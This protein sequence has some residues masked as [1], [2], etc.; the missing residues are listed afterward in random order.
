MALLP[1]LIAGV[2]SATRAP[3]P[4][5]QFPDA[6][7]EYRAQHPNKFK[8]RGGLQARAARARAA[9]RKAARM[10]TSGDT[11]AALVAGAQS[12]VSGTVSIPVLTVE[13]A[14]VTQPYPSS[15]LQQLLFDGPNPTGT[16]TDYYSEVSYGNLNV[17][18][19]VVDWAQLPSNDT[20]YEGAS[21]GL[22]PGAFS[23]MIFKKDFECN[24][25]VKK[26]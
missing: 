26:M 6:Y 10:A 12:V 19:T 5:Q 1:L 24:V 13:Y 20:V 16:L 15:T 8:L 21:N 9:Q 22:V 7:L 23:D 2:A 4:G 25:Y 11:A 3:Q 14:N 17:A 18:G